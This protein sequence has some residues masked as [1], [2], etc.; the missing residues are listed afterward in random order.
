MD[1]QTTHYSVRFGPLIRGLLLGPCVWLAMSSS[2]GA[3]TVPDASDPVGF[4]SVVADKMLRNTFSFGITNIPVYSNGVCVYTPAVQRL[5]RLSANIYDAANTNCFP[6]VFR[7]FFSKDASNNIF[8]IGYQQV[9]N[10]SGPTDP[11]LSPP[12]ALTQL[13][14]ASVT[15]IAD[16]NGPV[17]VYGVPWIIGAKKGLPNFNQ[18]YLVNASQMTRK[19]EVTRTSTDIATA[20]YA[21]NQMYVIGISNSLGVS[22]W[23]PYNTAYP[24]QLK[25]YAV[26][27]VYMTLTNGASTW[28]GYTGFTNG[29]TINANAWQGSQW[30]GTPPNAKPNLNSFFNLNWSFNFLNPSVY[31]FNTSSFDPVGSPTSS[32]FETTIPPLP[33]LPQFGLSTTNYLQAFIL[34]GSNVID[35]VQLSGLITSG[36]LNQP[37]ADPNYP[38][39]TGIHYQWSTNIY[40][41]SPPTPYGV[42][43]QLDVSGYPGDAPVAGGQWSTAPTSMG[44][45]TPLAESV[46]FEGFFVPTFQYNG[47]NYVNSQLSIQAPYTP[48]RTVYSSYLLQANDPLVHYL[49]SDLNSQYGTLAIWNSGQSRKNGFWYKSDDPINSPLPAPPAT[50]IGSRYQPWGQ[51]KQMMALPGVDTNAYNLAFKDPLVWGP[52]TWNFPTNLLAL[53]AGLGQVH[54][55]TPWQTVYLKEADLLKEYLAGGEPYFIGTNTWTQWTGDFDPYDA[56]LMAPVSDWRLTGLLLS[57]LNTNDATQLFS[58]NDP[59]I[60]DWQNMLNGLIVY[61][62]TATTITPTF[63]TYLMESNSAQA[64]MIADNIVQARASQANQNFYFIGDILAVPELTLSSPW[65]N[66]Y[67]SPI[68]IDFGI[69]DEAYEAIPAQLLPLLRPDSIGLLTPTNG[70]WTLWFSGADGYAYVLQTSTNLINWNNV[71]TNTPVQGGFN[72]P[73][74]PVS[75][76]PNYFYRSQ[77]LP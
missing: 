52:D 72:V 30:S 62:N 65:L 5:L 74:S 76:S 51:N 67:L 8:I 14:T 40:P 19:L 29:Y 25:L 73:I 57:L 20:T 23:N 17:N 42:I 35:Y 28:T 75:G 9:T 22:F 44:V 10:V 32:S 68:Q 12:Y 64:L 15:P 54:R 45:T 3:R 26:D 71:S 24:R 33:Q 34:D 41:S 58:V 70:D 1:F 18:F 37:L 47:V 36:G 43:N 6:S 31:R 2:A 61:S 60:A 27:Q 55:G 11:Q 69:T 16:A 13:S 49:A 59:N 48:T 50:P 46:Y 4:Y 39:Q 66:T 38:D 56:A 63:D 7:P 53:L 21:T 77:L